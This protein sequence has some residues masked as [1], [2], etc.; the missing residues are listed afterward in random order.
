MINIDSFMVRI[1]S[2]FFL[3]YRQYKL[4][5]DRR[6]TAEESHPGYRR[7]ETK[8]D[9]VFVAEYSMTKSDGIVNYKH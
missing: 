9:I 1:L 6:V 5:Y 4:Y 7:M 2:I 8:K 3:K